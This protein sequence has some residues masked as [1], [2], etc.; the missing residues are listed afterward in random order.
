[1]SRVIAAPRALRLL[2]ILAWLFPHRGQTIAASGRVGM[3]CRLPWTEQIASRTLYNACRLSWEP[4]PL[5]LASCSYADPKMKPSTSWPGTGCRLSRGCRLAIGL[6]GTGPTPSKRRAVCVSG[7]MSGTVRHDRLSAISAP[8]VLGTAMRNAPSGGSRSRLS[9]RV[10]ML[11]LLRHPFN[12]AERDE[13][14]RHPAR[15]GRRY[16]DVSDTLQF[17]LVGDFRA[18]CSAVIGTP[19]EA[20][21]AR[22]G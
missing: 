1:M 17:S 12:R 6:T 16:A 20:G 4:A 14:S 7:R 8:P 10:A 19:A 15:N 18:W 13:N 2:C 22:S 9:L 3:A 5:Q 11:R 21:A